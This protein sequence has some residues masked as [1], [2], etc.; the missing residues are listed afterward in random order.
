MIDTI[1]E[2][3]LVPLQ[4]DR[5][6]ITGVY[7]QGSDIL[8][9][10]DEYSDKDYSVVWQGKFPSA[11]DRQTLAEANKFQV[12]V[13]VDQEHKGTDRFMHQNIEHNIAHQLDFNF[14]AIYAQVLTEKV[15]EPKLYIL[16][17]FERGE[18]IYDPQNKLAEYKQKIK[19]TD[20]VKNKFLESRALSTKNNL[21]ALKI[22]ASRGQSVEFVKSLNYLLLTFG[23]QQYLENG[24]FP[25]SPKWLERDAEKYNWDNSLIKAVHKLKKTLNFGEV[26]NL[27]TQ[28]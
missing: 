9:Y 18:I 13:C 12:E 1:L 3:Y 23:I 14:F 21:E 16:G 22:A 2:Q 15:N 7:R 28:S 20:E 24:M 17:G 27:L 26:V 11:Q 5:L 8:G 25:N 4:T 19:V 6:K 10:S